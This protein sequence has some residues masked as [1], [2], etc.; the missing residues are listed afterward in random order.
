MTRLLALLTDFGAGSAYVGQMHLA[1]RRLAPEAVV[2]DVA[3]DCP[4]GDVEAGAYL[5]AGALREAPSAAVFV[6]VV[7]PGVGTARRILAARRG[8]LAVVG[9]D[10]GVLAAAIAGWEVRALEN[11]ALVPASPS[12]T[13][14]GR[15]IMAPAAVRLA[16]GFDFTAVG[17]AAA[18]QSAPQGPETLADGIA[19]RVLLTDR[20][21]NLVTNIPRRLVEMLGDGAHV[22]VRVDG[23]FIDGLSRTYGDVETG[24]ILAYIGS[25]DHLEI[26]VNGDS[27]A[28]LLGL[29]VDAP[30]RIEGRRR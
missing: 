24:N 2:V 10:N 14:H 20:F 23:A 30:I 11:R 9:P 18:P 15:D 26:A 6:V 27:A 12:A 7:D 13:F 19:G 29:G 8:D 17:P 4:P 21:G 16:T 3:H 25:G 1:I 22:R 28:R 5:L